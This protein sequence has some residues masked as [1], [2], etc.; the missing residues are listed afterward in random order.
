MER[1]CFTFTLRPG[2][3]EEYRR[4]HDE[5][6]PEMVVALTASGIANYTIFRRGREVIAY[7]E[8]EP[9]AATAFGRM[10]DTEV[11]QRWSVWFEDVIEALADEAG[12]L[13]WAEQVW[14]LE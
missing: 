11:N 2:M 4:R 8:C 7:C 1:C 3:E 10:G 9:D 6:W 14:H 5:I 13:R 12:E